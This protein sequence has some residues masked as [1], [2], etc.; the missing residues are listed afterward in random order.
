LERALAKEPRDRYGSSVE[1]AA[2]LERALTAPET[3]KTRRLGR[4]RGAAAGGTDA[5]DAAAGGDEA[6]GGRGERAAAGGDEAGR[7]AVGGDRAAGWASGGRVAEDGDRVGRGAAGAARGAAGGD[8]VGRGA[9][10]GGRSGAWAARSDRGAGEVP[11]RRGSV[12]LLAGISALLVLAIA[13]VIALVSGGGGSGGER[14][15]QSSTATAEPTRTSTPKKTATATA[16]ATGT[17]SPS[18]TATA[19]ATVASSGSPNLS[20][21]RS[22]QLAGYNARRSG[23]YSTA[24][25]KSRAALAACGDA[26]QLDPCGYALFEEGAALNRG[27]DP[28]AAIPVLQNRLDSYGDNASGEVAKELEDAQARASGKPGRGPKKNKNGASGG[29]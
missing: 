13:G 29:N 25:E 16:K 26:H 15:A 23:D 28:A 11:R 2:A 20:Q 5:A 8:G 24:L 22:F 3:A 10:A 17:P 9:V 14:R 21:A 18:A 12:A 27:G 6:A 1:F 19:T 4:R 7:A